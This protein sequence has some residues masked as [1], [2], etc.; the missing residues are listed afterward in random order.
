MSNITSILKEKQRT[1]VFVAHRLRTIFDADQIIVLENGTVAE[2]P[3]THDRLVNAGGVYS[4]LWA[5]QE[6]TPG[7]GKA[8]GDEVLE[9]EMAGEKAEEKK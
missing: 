2:R 3:G 4:R 7:I 6:T 5:A 8:L 9:K 1:S